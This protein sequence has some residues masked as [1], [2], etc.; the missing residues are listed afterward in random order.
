MKRI[1]DIFFSFSGLIITSPFLIIILFLVWLNDKRSP[2]YVSNRIGKRGKEFKMIKIR[3]MVVDADAN[4]VDSTS[5]DD[6]RIT[7]IGSFCRKIKI[8]ELPQLFNIF[9]GDMSFVG[10]R[11]NVRREVDIYTKEELELISIKP[12]LTDFASIVFSDEAEILVGKDDL[13]L[14]YNQ[15]VR[16]GKSKLGL[17]YV[18]NNNLTVDVFLIL[19]TLIN[20]FSRRM[21]LKLVVKL[22]KLQ[23]AG[24]H[25]VKIA[26]RNEPLYPTPPPGSKLVVQN[27]NGI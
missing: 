18:K 25:L 20:V 13:N 16:P 23:K 26:S 5:S 7:K 14:A 24:Y 10:P 9:V 3:T 17:F 15:L 1:F 12:G 21:S 22:L 8:D 2:F 27:R 4:N 6:K 19:I 11:P